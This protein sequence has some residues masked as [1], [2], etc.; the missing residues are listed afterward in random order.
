MIVCC[1]YNLKL[2]SLVVIIVSVVVVAE[3]RM[4]SQSIYQDR[5]ENMAHGIIDEMLSRSTTL[6]DFRNLLDEFYEHDRRRHERNLAIIRHYGAYSD[7]GLYI[8]ALNLWYTDLVDNVKSIAS[9]KMKIFK[10]E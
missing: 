3:S 6:D 4:K 1:R 2:I 9:E 5:P 8:E 7:W 10:E